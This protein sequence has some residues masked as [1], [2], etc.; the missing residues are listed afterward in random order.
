[1]ATMLPLGPVLVVEMVL[2]RLTGIREL[3]IVFTAYI[4]AILP[5]P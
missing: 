2:Y 5:R 1:M 4:D 3:P